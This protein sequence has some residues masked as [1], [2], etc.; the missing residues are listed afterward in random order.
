MTYKYTVTETRTNPLIPFYLWPP[1]VRQL[2]ME[3]GRI[4]IQGQESLT[5]RITTS[6][7]PSQAAWQAFRDHPEVNEHY[8]LMDQYYAKAKIT[9]NKQEI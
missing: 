7:W 2:A 3:L 5:E 4:S 6:E 9:F 8:L 1:R